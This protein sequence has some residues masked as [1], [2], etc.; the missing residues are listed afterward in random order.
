MRAPEH[1]CIG[2]PHAKEIAMIATVPNLVV[3]LLAHATGDF[4]EREMDK[5]AEPLLQKLQADGHI[6]KHCY[7]EWQGVY[8]HG[9]VPVFWFDQ[10]FDSAADAIHQPAHC[11]NVNADGSIDVFA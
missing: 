5:I 8:E 9:L 4:T 1:A 10:D 3:D 7:V 2:Q 11:L 6:T